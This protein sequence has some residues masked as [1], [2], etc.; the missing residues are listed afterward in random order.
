MTKRND[1][2]PCGSGKK[3]K[4]C[5]SV[6]SLNVIQPNKCGECKACCTVLGVHE[7]SKPEFQKCQHLTGSGC[8]VYKDRP[9]SC[10]DY[11]CLWLVSDDNID[12]LRPDQI[13]VILEVIES[14]ERNEVNLVVR[15]VWNNSFYTE[16]AQLWVKV[17]VKNFDIDLVF[18]IGDN[19][20]RKLI[21]PPN[22][23]YKYPNGVMVNDVTLG[24]EVIRDYTN[25]GVENG[26]CR[27]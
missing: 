19:G 14:E 5:C 11:A 15:E 20:K 10:K 16:L 27:A 4:R 26:N 22:K 24:R 3:Y 8:G 25:Q 21:I 18:V 2:C 17:V 1:P 6:M 12:I 9:N 23:M 7:L 13:G